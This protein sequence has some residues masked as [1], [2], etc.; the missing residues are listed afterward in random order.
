MLK[1]YQ[2]PNIAD[3][4][5]EIGTCVTEP[6]EVAALRVAFRCVKLFEHSQLGLGVER[7]DP[8]LQPASAPAFN[9]LP[10]L[11]EMGTGRRGNFVNP[12]PTGLI[13][14]DDGVGG[15]LRRLVLVPSDG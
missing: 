7:L 14:G 12:G 15:C 8:V 3:V 2:R 11:P 4:A 9:N 1:A 13:D 5:V 6:D 10:H